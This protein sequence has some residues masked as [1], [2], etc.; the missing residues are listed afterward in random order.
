MYTEESRGSVVRIYRA[1][2]GSSEIWTIPAPYR[3]WS[4]IGRAEAE[5]RLDFSFSNFSA[6]F[7]RC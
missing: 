7:L 5:R 4:V 2:R 3:G 6:S 1:S